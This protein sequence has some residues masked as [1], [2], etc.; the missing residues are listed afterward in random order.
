MSGPE[1]LWGDWE[2]RLALG[3]QHIIWKAREEQS[4]IISANVY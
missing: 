1:E 2:G 3:S 4:F